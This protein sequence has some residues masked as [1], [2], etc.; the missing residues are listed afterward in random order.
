MPNS[1]PHRSGRLG[2][3]EL[4]RSTASSKARQIRGRA[5]LALLGTVAA[6]LLG[7]YAWAYWTSIGSG[8]ASATTSTLSTPTSVTAT[9]SSSTVHVSWAASTLSNGQAAQGY[10]ATR[11]RNSDSQRS[12]ACGSSS[13]TLIAT[14]SCNDTP[15]PDGSYHYQITGVYATW[16]AVSSS[17][18]SVVVDTIAPTVTI[19][20][21]AGQAD[22]TTRVADQLHG[23]VQRVGHGVR[24]RP[25]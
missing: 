3:T 20:Q 22:P 19:N 6:L 14:T 13:T 21:A 2:G 11:I 10:Y 7:T 24:R 23:G 18:N 1:R 15:V 17:S 8:T 9:P 25:T 16:T 4:D 12:A 5:L